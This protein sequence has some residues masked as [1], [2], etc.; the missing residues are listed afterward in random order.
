MGTRRDAAVRGA[1][2]KSTSQTKTVAG[3]SH[4]GRQ[5]YFSAPGMLPRSGLLEPPFWVDDLSEC[6]VSARITGWYHRVLGPG[7][8][9][10]GDDSERIE[11]VTEECENKAT[12]GRGLSV[13]DR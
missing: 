1:E 2:Q 8:I 4:G 7:T 12:K 10:V 3:T 11:H 9:T 5:D 13:F 6:I